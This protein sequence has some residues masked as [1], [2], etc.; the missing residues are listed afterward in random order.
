M[1]TNQNQAPL[2][3]NKIRKGEMSGLMV[4]YGGAIC[5]MV[6]F[7][8]VSGFT[9]KLFMIV[10]IL[11]LVTLPIIS[12]YLLKRLRKAD[13]SQP[14]NLLQH[15]M[16]FKKFQGL[17]VSIGL[18][19]LLIMTPLLAAIK[20]KNIADDP[21][22]WTVRFPLAVALFLGYAFWVHRSYKKALKMV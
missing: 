13:P 8:D 2:N 14:N 21:Y 18:F 1:E 10:A 4:T 5:L 6:N 22:F 17:S 9:M 7:T 3:F 16:R 12:L 20:G 19:M 11:A 15:K